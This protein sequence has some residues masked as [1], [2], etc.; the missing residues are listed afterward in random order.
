MSVKGVTNVLAIPV[1]CIVS[2]CVDVSGGGSVL[3]SLNAHEH[4]S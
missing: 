1:Q 3:R 2:M 4:A